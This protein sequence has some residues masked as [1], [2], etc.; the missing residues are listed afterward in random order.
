MRGRGGVEEG[1][2]VF[3]KIKDPDPG[4]PKKTG[5]I[6]LNPDSQHWF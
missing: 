6:Q 1:G 4:D 5:W 3:L 2:K